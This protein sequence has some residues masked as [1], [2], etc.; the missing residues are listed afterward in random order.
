VENRRERENN[1]EEREKEI[2]RKATP[3]VVESGGLRFVDGWNNEGGAAT[4][5]HYTAQGH[6]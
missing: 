3:R 5:Q 2:V 6:C 4:L 1:E